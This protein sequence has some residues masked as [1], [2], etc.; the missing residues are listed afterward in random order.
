MHLECDLCGE[1]LYTDLSD[2]LQREGSQPHLEAEVYTSQEPDR[3]KS[4]VDVEVTGK[5][6]SFNC[7]RNCHHPRWLIDAGTGVIDRKGYKYALACGETFVRIVEAPKVA[8]VFTVTAT[9]LN[10]PNATLLLMPA[11]GDPLPSILVEDPHKTTL[12]AVLAQCAISLKPGAVPKF[13]LEDGSLLTK[14]DFDKT[15][16]ETFDRQ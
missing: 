10:T 15:F 16:A 5:G 9:H 11:S 8:T 3:L 2:F 6:R 12:G 7:S 14:E 1:R 13:I 4:L